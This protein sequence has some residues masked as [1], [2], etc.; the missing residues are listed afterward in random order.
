YT[1]T[2]RPREGLSLGVG[3]VFVFD[4]TNAFTV[5]AKWDLTEKWRV[6]AEAQYDYK[7]D[8]FINRKAAVG[9]DFHDFRFEAVFE[10]D[11]GRDERR[12][13]VTFVPTFLRL[14]R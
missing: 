4:V 8:E 14:S 9:R 3:Q 11:A 6:T 10:E 13:Y 7:T 1:V 2:V 5:G 12:F